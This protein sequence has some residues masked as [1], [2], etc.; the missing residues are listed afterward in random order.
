M[1]LLQTIAVIDQSRQSFV[2]TNY[3]LSFKNLYLIVWGKCK[4]SI[5]FLKYTL[6]TCT[7]LDDDDHY[8]SFDDFKTVLW[9]HVSRARYC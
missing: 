4:K 9:W 5:L 8:N 1:I 6:H 7:E 3:L 2:V